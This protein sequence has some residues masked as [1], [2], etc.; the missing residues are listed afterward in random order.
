VCSPSG[1][2]RQSD[3][4]ARCKT[5]SAWQAASASATCAIAAIFSW[6]TIRMV[7]SVWPSMASEAVHRAVSSSGSGKIV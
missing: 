3:D 5:P 2:T 1:T 7:T 6:R 4:S